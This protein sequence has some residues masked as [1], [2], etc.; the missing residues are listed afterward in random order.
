MVLWLAAQPES[1]KLA[2]ASA[3]N[4]ELSMG[5]EASGDVAKIIPAPE[6]TEGLDSTADV[7][8]DDIQVDPHAGYRRDLT[9][10]KGATMLVE[11]FANNHDL[12]GNAPDDW[13]PRRL[14]P[15]PP[16]GFVEATGQAHLRLLAACGVPAGLATDADGTSQREGFRRWW[17]TVVDPVVAL[18]EHEL[19]V[20]L[21]RPVSL[22]PDPIRLWHGVPGDGGSEAGRR[23]HGPIHRAGRGWSRAM[24]FKTLHPLVIPRAVVGLD[25]GDPI[26]VS[27]EDHT[28][29][30]YMGS[31]G[32]AFVMVPAGPAT[33]TLGDRR[34]AEEVSIVMQGR[35]C[36][37]HPEGRVSRVTP[38]WAD[39]LLIREMGHRERCALEEW[40][41]LTS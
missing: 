19:T 24:M 26:Y 35:D 14:G 16:A 1:A 28:G 25:P 33:L 41:R 6:G 34:N 21:E 7:D 3:A 15:K 13:R 8:N 23:R 27:G 20:K 11:S 37:L 22:E 18:I 17:L 40:R 32:D 39:L 5:R 4:A 2:A 38:F 29:V 36:L 30:T 12:G 31:D 10:A 9:T